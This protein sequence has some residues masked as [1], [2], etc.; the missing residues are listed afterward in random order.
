MG[1]PL[2]LFDA[3][4]LA[5]SIF[6]LAAYHTIFY[7]HQRTAGMQLSFN[8]RNVAHWLH[9]H[10]VKS[11]PQSGTLAIH[12]LR[13]TIMVGVFIGGY[14]LNTA[15][16]SA[17]D[18][19]N[20][21]NKRKQVRALCLAILLFGSFLCWAIVIRHAAHLGYMIGTLDFEDKSDLAVLE[22][23]PG[24]GT[25]PTSSEEPG[26][27]AS[28]RTKSRVEQYPFDRKVAMKKS[29]YILQSLL[30]YFRLVWV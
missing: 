13:N 12:T 7:Y 25:D 11:D 2:T 6:V 10:K 22:R 5:A 14:A 15:Y 4:G 8:I 20:G 24:H 26:T 1:D 18:Y 29:E 30:M 27:P 17:L 16:T 3:V 21:L 23:L 28:V 9:K 19:I